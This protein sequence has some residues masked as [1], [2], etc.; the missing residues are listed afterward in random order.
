M[1]DIDRLRAEYAGRASRLAHSDKYSLFDAA[2]LFTMQQRR[3]DVIALLKRHGLTPL[4]D[5]C[6]LEIGCGTG[7]VLIEWLQYGIRPDCLYGVELLPQRISQAQR[8]LSHLPLIQGDGRHTAY[9]DSAFDIVLQFTVLSSILDRDVQQALA[10]EML[11]VLKPGG[12]ILSYDFWLNPTNKQTVGMTKR[13]LRGLFPDSTLA[14]YRT[15]LAPPMARRIVP[16][17]WLAAALLEKFAL[18][19]SHYLAVIRPNHPNNS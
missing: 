7:G 18:F 16:V 1:D 14:F 19:N 10:N 8:L 11:R 17:S 9:R 3:R 13:R 12:V 5:K 2:N 4:A 6:V 15:T